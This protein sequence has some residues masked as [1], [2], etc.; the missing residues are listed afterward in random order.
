MF[1]EAKKKKYRQAVE[2]EKSIER[3]ESIGREKKE[4]E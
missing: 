4:S 1:Q 3:I 2:E